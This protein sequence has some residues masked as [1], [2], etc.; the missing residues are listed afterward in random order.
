MLIYRKWE[1]ICKEV[2][3]YKISNT[4]S[5]VLDRKLDNFLVFK[6]DV[7]T[8]PKKALKIA[9]IENKYGHK[10]S[11]YVQ[12]YLLKNKKNIAILNNIKSLGHEVTYH[13]DVMDSNSGNLT[14][15]ELEFDYYLD[16]FR[17]NSFN[18]VTVCQH[19]NPVI[20][21]IGYNSNRDF[22]RSK[23]IQKKYTDI[24]DIMVNFKQKLNKNYLYISDAGRSWKIIA[25]PEYND[26]DTSQEDIVLKNDKE[27]VDTI[28]KTEKIFISIHPHRAQKYLIIAIINS[29]VFKLIKIMVLVLIKIPIF[30]KLANKFY[31]LAKKI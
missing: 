12:G 22:F 16:L 28:V 31:Y 25:N 9:Q 3:K 13:H 29:L 10:G 24:F 19:G 26:I 6:H 1:K 5:L 18:V 4:A 14:N 27:L 30:K 20:N 17:K 15:A 8:N 11:Y 23:V 7:E 21:R 2:A